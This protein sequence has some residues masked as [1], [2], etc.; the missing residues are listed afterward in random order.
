MLITCPREHVFRVAN[1]SVFP[2][3]HDNVSSREPAE[4]VTTC[5]LNPAA[6]TAAG[7]QLKIMPLSSIS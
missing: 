1:V 6:F 3:S 7:T 2:A 5:H 4:N